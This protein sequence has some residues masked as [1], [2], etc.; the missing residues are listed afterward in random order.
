MLIGCGYKR[1]LGKEK[2][3]QEPANQVLR[4]YKLTNSSIYIVYSLLPYKDDL[5]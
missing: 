2:D 5:A 1:S 4:L 3:V